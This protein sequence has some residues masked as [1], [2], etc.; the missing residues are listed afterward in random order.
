[1]WDSVPWFVGGGAQH[2]PEVAR[3][4]AYAATSGAEGIVNTGD[5]KVSA[6]PTPSSKVVVGPGAGLIINRAAGG[7][8][9]TYIGRNASDDQVSVGAQGSGSTRYDLVVARIEDPFMAGE[10]WNDPADAKIGP[11]IFSRVI[12]NVG[13]ANIASHW[14]AKQYLINSGYSAEPLAGITIPPSTATI[15][16][17]MIK[18][19]REVANP[20]RQREVRVVLPSDTRFSVP[21][22]NGRVWFPFVNETVA[23][24]DWATR[25][26][27]VVTA[28]SLLFDT[29]VYQGRIRAEYGWNGTAVT[30]LNTDEAGLDSPA[31]RNRQTIMMAGDLAIPTEFRG[32]THFVRTGTLTNGGITGRVVADDW[33][34]ITVDIEFVEVAE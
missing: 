2:S 16:N 24:P 20:R 21:S 14:A 27:L 1:M 12:P 25:A 28:S 19:L 26:R 6:T 11:Y 33:T 31:A 18:D 8:Q 23:C 4:L 17:A 34:T 9:Q 3:L 32:K 30:S 7:N 10:P 22:G 5:L 15:T 29:G 13:Q